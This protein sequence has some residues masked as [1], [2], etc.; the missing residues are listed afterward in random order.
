MLPKHLIDREEYCLQAES[1]LS[2]QTLVSSVLF[3]HSGN[4]MATGRNGSSQKQEADYPFALPARKQ[5]A[6]RKWSLL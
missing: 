4:D 6:N 1:S 2:Q 5:S 3:H